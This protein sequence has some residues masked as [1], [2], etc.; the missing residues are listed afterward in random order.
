MV[1]REIA[2]ARLH[3]VF[4]GAYAVG[5]P[6]RNERSRLMAATLACGSGAV[7]SHRSAGSLLGLLDKGPW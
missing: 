1:K 2:A 3:R 6:H 5:H 7:V 4:R